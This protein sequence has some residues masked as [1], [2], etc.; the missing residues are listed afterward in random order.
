MD[1]SRLRW[2]D[3]VQCRSGLARVRWGDPMR[4]WSRGR[5]R[6]RSISIACDE[7]RIDVMDTPGLAMG[8]STRTVI[9][10][11]TTVTQLIVGDSRCGV[12][13]YQ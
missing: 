4:T 12:R 9:E 8:L 6:Q 3:P 7:G 2:I 13:V 10:G 1:S 11:T 5:Y